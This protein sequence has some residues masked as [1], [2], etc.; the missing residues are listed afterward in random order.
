MPTTGGHPY[1]AATHK[2]GASASAL[3]LTPHTQGQCTGSGSRL[4][5]DNGRAGGREYRALRWRWAGREITRKGNDQE[6][7]KVKATERDVCL[8]ERVNAFGFMSV[9]QIAEFWQVEFSTAA[10]RVRKLIEA[11]LLLRLELDALSARPLVVTKAG[12]ALVGDTIPPMRGIRLGTYRHDTMMV[13]LALAMERRFGATF[14]TE[15]QLRSQPGPVAGHLPDGILH[16][17]DGRRVGAE[18]ELTQKSQQRLSNIMAIHAGNLALDA[19]WYVIV[20]EAMRPVLARV[21]ADYPHIRI[22]KW[23]PP[24]RRA[25]AQAPSQPGDHHDHA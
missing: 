2:Y 16:L 23:T 14:E 25:A 21:S 7:Q 9:E 24:A 5:R 17:P 13:D 12:C 6:G 10:R 11:G 8:L 4:W 22:V 1:A 15:R 19:V 18:L 20:N 3:I